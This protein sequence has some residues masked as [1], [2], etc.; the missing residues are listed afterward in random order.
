M[1]VG[2]GLAGSRLG[3][4]CQSTQHSK[5]LKRRV[6][7]SRQRLF[8]SLLFSVLNPSAKH[9]LI[10]PSF[11][12]PHPLP[13]YPSSETL[14]QQ[15][16]GNQRFLLPAWRHRFLGNRLVIDCISHGI[17]MI[18]N[19]LLLTESL[20]L[21]PSL[22]LTCAFGRRMILLQRTPCTNLA[23]IPTSTTNFFASWG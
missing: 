19:V 10:T 22:C 20:Y 13:L 14:S 16:E 8:T 15:N 23:A 17:G 18:C 12:F 6:Y 4:R 9:H 21:R 11:R 2:G 3:V 5:C 7:S 1:A